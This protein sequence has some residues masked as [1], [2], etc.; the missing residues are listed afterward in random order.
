MLYTDPPSLGLVLV[1]C[2]LICLVIWLDC[3][4]D[5]YYLHSVQSPTLLLKWHSLDVCTA[6][7]GCVHSYPRMT[8]VFPVFSLTF[9]F[10]DFSV[11]LSASICWCQSMLFASTDCWLP[12]L[13]CGCCLF[14]ENAL[15]NKLLYSVLYFT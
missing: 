1:V 4:N 13:F 9:S 3:F 8:V 10:P 5:V 2:L 14:F 6:T 12:V 7:L 11:K 15:G